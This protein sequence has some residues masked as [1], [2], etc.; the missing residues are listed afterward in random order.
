MPEK[1]ASRPGV[2]A[3]KTHRFKKIEAGFCSELDW[4]GPLR[5]L[6]Q[7]SQSVHFSSKVG[8]HCGLDMIDECFNLTLDTEKVGESAPVTPLSQ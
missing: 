2:L 1:S 6:H 8:T 7:I 4:L 3:N 5:P